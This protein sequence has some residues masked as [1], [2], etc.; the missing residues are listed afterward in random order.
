M[1]DSANL[2]TLEDITDPGVEDAVVLGEGD[3][4]SDDDDLGDAAEYEALGDV[5]E[6]DE[7]DAVKER[8]LDD[9]EGLDDS[10]AAEY[11]ALGDGVLPRKLPNLAMAKLTKMKAYVVVL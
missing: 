9:V 7:G 11:D 2:V 1:V 6:S 4:H 5:T 3:A 8:T 10:D